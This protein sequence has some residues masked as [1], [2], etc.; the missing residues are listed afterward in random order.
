MEVYGICLN[1]LKIGNN[2]VSRLSEAYCRGWART[3]SPFFRGIPQIIEENGGVIHTNKREPLPLLSQR[4][5]HWQVPLNASLNA[6]S[7][8]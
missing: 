3:G 5:Y 4:I 7:S 8:H 2:V 1:V 6:V